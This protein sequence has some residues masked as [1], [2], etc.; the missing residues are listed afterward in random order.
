MV[1]LDDIA[2][3]ELRNRRRSGETVAELAAAFSVSERHVRRL[4][5]VWSR[6]CHGSWSIPANPWRR[7]FGGISRGSSVTLLMMF[8]RRPRWLL[9]VVLDR[10]DGRAAAPLAR[11]L[12]ALLGSLRGA[13]EPG[14]LEEIIRRRDQRLLA[15]AAGNYV[16]TEGK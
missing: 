10:A 8:G 1:K 9:R 12:S 2:V 4:T 5:A 11:E 7:R 3:E 16:T 13:R 14:P 6:R 15:M